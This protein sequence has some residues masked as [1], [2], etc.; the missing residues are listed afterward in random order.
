[1]ALDRTAF[2]HWTHDCAVIPMTIYSMW[3][4]KFARDEM[5]MR[6]RWS[7]ARRARREVEID[8][9]LLH[10]EDHGAACT[11]DVGSDEKKNSAG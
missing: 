11:L 10:I 5:R 4:L 6:A 7:E 2:E 1:M 3:R 8:A 9:V